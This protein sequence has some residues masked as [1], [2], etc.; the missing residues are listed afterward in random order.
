MSVDISTNK[1]NEILGK[2]IRSL[3]SP[4]IANHSFNLFVS[5]CII[6]LKE[7]VESY[8]YYS[9]WEEMK[10]F[11]GLRQIT[12]NG[13]VLFAASCKCCQQQPWSR[14]MS[15]I[16]SGLCLVN[17]LARTIFDILPTQHVQTGVCWSRPSSICHGCKLSRGNICQAR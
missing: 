3:Q 4:N 12:I 11:I 10:S 2:I 9:F 6:A 13:K 7:N 15:F 16:G 8:I 5:F 14:C 1:S 17:F